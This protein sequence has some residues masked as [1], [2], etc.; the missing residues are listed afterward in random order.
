MSFSC[1]A[2]LYFLNHVEHM[3]NVHKFITT[4][5]SLM[6]RRTH[7]HMKDNGQTA[8]SRQTDVAIFALPI[9]VPSE[10]VCDARNDDGSNSARLKIK[11]VRLNNLTALIEIIFK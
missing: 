3:H 5:Q 6:N 11:T 10:E 7:R 1:V 9:I 2:H 8:L 4:V